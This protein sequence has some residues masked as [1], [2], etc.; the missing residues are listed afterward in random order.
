MPCFS[1][2]S[3]HVYFAHPQNLDSIVHLAVRSGC[4]LTVTAIL[5]HVS[6]LARMEEGSKTAIPDFLRLVNRDAY[7]PSDLAALMFP[8]D[9]ELHRIL[10]PRPREQRVGL[11]NIY[12][13]ISFNFGVQCVPTALAERAGRPLAHRPILRRSQCDC[14][15]P[16]VQPV[17]P[18]LCGWMP[19]CRKSV[20]C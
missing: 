9:E 11:S 19:R 18:C 5:T 4:K 16:R 1:C 17:S 15:S 3:F 20:C 7:T 14:E 8:G 6:G 13:Y 2:L 10:S 12:M